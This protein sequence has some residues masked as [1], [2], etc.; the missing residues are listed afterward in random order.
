MDTEEWRSVPS[1]P[2]IM[3]SSWGRIKLPDRTAMMPHG[4]IR[5]YSTKPLYGYITR[6]KPT[7]KHCYMG[8]ANRTYGNLKV[9]QLVCEAFHGPRPEGMTDVLHLAEDGLNNRPANLR[10]NLNAPGHI[11]YCA[12]ACREKMAGRSPE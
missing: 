6:A 9:H 5:S 7:A 12:S 3:A 2:G 1:K 10:E 8:I 11:A 4:G